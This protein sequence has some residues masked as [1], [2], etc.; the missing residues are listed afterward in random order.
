MWHLQSLSIQKLR[1]EVY[2]W[3]RLEHQH[4]LPLY[5]I[6]G[7]FDVVPALVSPWMEN[8][9]LQQ[10]LKTMWDAEQLPP[11]MHRLFRLVSIFTI[12]NESVHS[13]D[14]IHGDLMPSNVLID[15][16][17]NALLADFGLSRLLAD[18]ETSFFQ[19]HGPG[20]IRWAAPE[21]IPLNPDTPNGEV[22]KPNKE[23][24][25]YSFGCIMMQV[26]S[27]Q[28]PYSHILSEH[29]VTVAK[30]QGTPPR[31]PP[32]IADVHWRYIDRCLSLDVDTRPLVDEVLEYIEVEYDRHN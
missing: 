3:Q 7:N 4:I 26:L 29:T 8:G 11:E 10:Y 28:P 25:I 32:A 19:S 9:S 30:F 13:K 31:Q 2:L 20:A 17:G 12:H 22:S 18:H 16:D 27:G 23:S 1:Q 5:G 15:E 21:I 24:D 14:I 6:T